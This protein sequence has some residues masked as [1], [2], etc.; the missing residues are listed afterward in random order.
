MEE[1]KEKDN[2]SIGD[3]NKRPLNKFILFISLSLIAVFIAGGYF[4]T[5][6]LIS[7][8]KLVEQKIKKKESI[9][10]GIDKK[11]S[12]QDLLKKFSSYPITN[13]Y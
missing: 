3:S 10:N 4:L 11:I 5:N 12:G 8:E 7:N 6:K 1:I 9:V 13:G 2:L